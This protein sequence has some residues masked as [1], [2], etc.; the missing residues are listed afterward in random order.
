MACNSFVSFIFSNFPL[1]VNDDSDFAAETGKGRFRCVD[2]ETGFFNQ[3][4]ISTIVKYV[5]DY[6]AKGGSEPK[7]N[8]NGAN[9]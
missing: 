9:Q 2:K 4:Y 6:Q 1:P 7:K 5:R 8:Q 3:K